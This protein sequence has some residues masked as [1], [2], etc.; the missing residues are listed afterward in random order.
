MRQ[1]R[2]TTPRL[3]F[4]CKFI[5]ESGDAEAAREMNIVIVTMAYLGRQDPKAAYDK[6]ASV[7]T[8][9]LAALR[10]QI[11]HV[12]T[13]PPVERLHRM[14]SQILPG[15]THPSCQDYYRDSDLRN[16]IE[17][18]LSETGALARERG[19]RLSMH[20]GQFCVIASLNPSALKNGV[21]EFEY[22]TEI[23]ELMGFGGGWHPHGAHINIHAGA[24][25]VGAEGFRTGLK[26]LSEA[27]RNLITVEN[28]EVS[29][30]LDDLLP[31]AGSL[32]IV[33][34][35]HHHWIASRGEYIEPE[36][37]RIAV[38]QESWRGVRPVSHVSVSREDLLPDHDIDAPPDFGALIAAGIKP[39]DLRAHSDLMWNE[40]VNDLVAR[41]M[42]WSDFE[43]EAKLKN[44]ASE[45]IAN[46]VEERW[47]AAGAAT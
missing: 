27:A 47:R 29:Y 4:C 26:G 2:I 42:A 32:P 37:P 18:S 31:L 20:P 36:D 13:R 33:L 40:A 6:L 35:L 10:R 46:H 11:E 3:G 25:A 23:M 43:I 45:G 9:N 38:I 12:A 1:D 7:V 15:Y 28:D 21:E 16:L 41:H 24:R 30:G 14:A 34:D 22:H 5:P 17:R 39:K 44:I 8:H 19:V